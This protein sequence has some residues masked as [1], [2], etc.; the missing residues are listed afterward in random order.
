MEKFCKFYLLKAMG[1]GVHWLKGD[2]SWVQ[3][4]VTACEALPKDV[5]FC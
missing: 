5:A 4:V 1:T 2:V 3:N